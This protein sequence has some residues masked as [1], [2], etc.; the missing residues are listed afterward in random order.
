MRIFITGG[1]GYIGSAVVAALVKAGHEVSGLV[2]SAESARVLEAMGGRAVEGDLKDGSTYA[3]AAAKAEALVHAAFEYSARGVEADR[4]AVDTLLDAARRTKALVLY[5]SGCWVLGNTGDGPADESASTERAAELVAWRPAH[6]RAVLEAGDAAG[7]PATAVIR[8]GMVY[9]G[10]G[11]LASHLFESAVETGAAEY[12]GDG[13]NRWSMVHREDLA[14]LYRLVVER[15]AR[16]IFH[17]VDGHAARVAEAARAAS[18]AAGKGGATRSVPLEEARRK[19]GP[20]AD[21][22]CLDQVLAAP[23]SAELGWRPA[24]ASFVETA[25]ASFAEWR[26]G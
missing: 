9:G 4:T 23:R 18:E 8:P 13:A 17:G 22:L 7:G 15:T 16:G 11:G 21:A 6:E 3:A 5:T 26:R 2:R 24:R 20:V 25:P 12:V 1:T 19:L 14:D 10:R